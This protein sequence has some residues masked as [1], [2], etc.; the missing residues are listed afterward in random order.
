MTSSGEMRR[1]DVMR[2]GR[3]EYRACWALQR[4]LQERRI[5]GEI[6]DVL[7][8]TEHDPVITLGTTANSGHLLTPS[9]V[10]SGQG[11][12][13]VA[14]NRGGDVTFHGPGQIVGY[15]IFDLTQHTPD[16]HVYLRQIEALVSEALSSFGVRS[17]RVKGY[18]GVWV[19]DEKIC[20]IGIHVRRWVTMHGFALNVNTDLSLFRHI[21]PCGITDHGVTSLALL[22]GRSVPVRQVED[23]LLEACERVFH[24]TLHETTS[25]ELGIDTDA[26]QR[27]A[28]ECL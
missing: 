19:G 5:A 20:A 16:L 12:D 23:A 1:V 8:L 9:R 14:S 22:L 3:T 26:L 4:S 21:V 15:P 27:S 11:I 18:T 7:L 17:T 28:A 6:G 24:V 25:K 2:L 13:V 10:L